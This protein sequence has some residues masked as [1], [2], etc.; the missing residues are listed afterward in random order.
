MTPSTIAI[1]GLSRALAKYACRLHEQTGGGHSV[2]SALGVWLLLALASDTVADGDRADLVDLLGMPLD[3]AKNLATALLDSP[4]P[5]VSSAIAAWTRP[6]HETPALRTWIETL[7]SSLTR[8]PVPSQAEADAWAADRTDG[9]IDRFPLAV[10]EDTLLVLASALA[11]KVD[12][13][14]PFEPASVESTPGGATSWP[15]NVTTVLRSPAHVRRYILSAEFCDAGDVAVHEARAEGLLVVSLA[16]G[17]DV[18]QAHVIA[19]AHRVACA[20][21]DPWTSGLEPLERSLFDLELGS[22]PCWHLVEG[23]GLV[24]S[25]TGREERVEAYLPAWQAETNLDLATEPDLG[26][27]PVLSGLSQ[28]VPD[29]RG[30]LVEARQAAK[31]SFSQTGFTAAAVTAFM[32]RATGAQAELREGVVR[33]ATLHFGGPHAVVAVALD[34][35]QFGGGAK[36]P[37]GKWHGIPCSQLG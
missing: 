19:A 20:A 24:T 30:H 28:L 31:A 13:E 17:P 34:S 5:Q 23:P 15:S 11:T 7:P 16:A 1:A 3:E 33:T 35:P 2:T 26:V 6:S 36:V 32:M 29:P 9:L 4:H 18:S 27:G 8:G 22:H 25:T 14:A 12:W 21:M 37:D 10:T